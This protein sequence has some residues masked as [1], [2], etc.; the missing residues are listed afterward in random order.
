M[1][2]ITLPTLHSRCEF[3]NA[4][5][6]FMATEHYKNG[7]RFEIESAYGGYR[8]CIR[9]ANTNMTDLSPRGT[10]RE[11]Y[12]FIDGVIAGFDIARGF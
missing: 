2:R 5:V 6:T 7:D 10:G 12:D 4:H 9:H 1:A 11:V 3:L 8:L